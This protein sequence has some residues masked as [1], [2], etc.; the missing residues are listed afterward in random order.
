MPVNN[1]EIINKTPKWDSKCEQCLAC[2][3][4]CPFK[5]IE[6]DNRTDKQ[7]RYHNPNV[8]IRDIVDSSPSGFK[9]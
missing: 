1:I 7:M 4:W 2:I 8:T 5:A 9:L 3:N 6:F